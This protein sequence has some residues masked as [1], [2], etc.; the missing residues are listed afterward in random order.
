MAMSAG[1]A[2]SLVL[3]ALGVAMMM[4]LQRGTKRA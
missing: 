3:L 2:A 1:R 4:V